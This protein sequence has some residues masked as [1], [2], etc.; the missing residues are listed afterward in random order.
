MGKITVC[1][2]G[3][4]IPHTQKYGIL[5]VACGSKAVALFLSGILLDTGDPVL[6]G[7]H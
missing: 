2:G 1:G 5:A 4:D 6:T 7:P 3:A